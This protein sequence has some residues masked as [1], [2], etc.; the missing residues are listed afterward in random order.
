[1]ADNSQAAQ[2]AI[3]LLEEEVGLQ[4]MP[5]TRASPEGL[6]GPEK[7]PGRQTQE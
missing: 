1:M 2:K 3:I 5:E 4:E 6:S 7:T